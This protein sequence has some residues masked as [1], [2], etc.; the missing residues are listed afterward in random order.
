MPWG[1]LQIKNLSIVNSVVRYEA[2]P[3]SPPFTVRFIPAGV[4]LIQVKDRTQ[5]YKPSRSHLGT[6]LAKRA[7]PITVGYLTVAFIDKM[8]EEAS[9]L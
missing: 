7:D 1:K 3:G 9:E 4:G 2:Q 8:L 6:P 5:L